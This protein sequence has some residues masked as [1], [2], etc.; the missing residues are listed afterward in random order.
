[1]DR[2]NFLRCLVGI[3]AAPAVIRLAPLMRIAPQPI[4]G[5]DLARGP[6]MTAIFTYEPL[7]DEPVALDFLYRSVW[8][9][10]DWIV[11][12][13][14]ADLPFAWKNSAAF[15][16]KCNLEFNLDFSLPSRGLAVQ[17]ARWPDAGATAA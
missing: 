9:R 14:Y 13:N 7:I 17:P 5:L 12:A 15:I 1:M 10:P 2:R 3:I 16:E 8:A 11:G 6:D 4:I